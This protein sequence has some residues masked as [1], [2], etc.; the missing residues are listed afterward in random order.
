MAEKQLSGK[1]AANIGRK[2]AVIS[3]FKLL[4]LENVESVQRVHAAAYSA[5][6]CAAEKNW[7]FAPSK[8]CKTQKVA[9]TWSVPQSQH[10]KV[11]K[12]IKVELG[13]KP[14]IERILSA[15]RA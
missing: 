9:Q 14:I 5:F 1:I 10:K 2:R 4:L 3:G 12:Q 7:C 8:L 11:D 15:A 13:K 6:T